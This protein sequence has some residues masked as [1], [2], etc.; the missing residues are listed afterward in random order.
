MPRKLL[1]IPL[2]EIL[3]L[4]GFTYF[5]SLLGSQELR[6]LPLVLAAGLVI[7]LAE[8]NGREFSL[9]QIAITSILV[10][11]V[12]VGL[13]QILGFIIP[14]LSKDIDLISLSNLVRLATICVVAV[15]GHAGLFV[16]VRYFCRSGRWKHTPP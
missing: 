16:A 4:L 14:K 7:W 11:L 10:S 3:G 13:F 9:K 5:S 6:Y 1:M 8:K 12:F 2:L 15:V